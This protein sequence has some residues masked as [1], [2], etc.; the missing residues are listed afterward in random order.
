MKINSGKNC[1]I[2]IYDTNQYPIKGI[3]YRDS[4]VLYGIQLNK[5]TGSQMLYTVFNARD[6]DKGNE[7]YVRIKNYINNTEIDYILNDDPRKDI[8]ERET[9]KQNDPLINLDATYPSK[10]D[11]YYTIC[12]MIFPDLTG[13]ESIS[14]WMQ[15]YW[16]LRKK[17]FI[18]DEYID[19]LFEGQTE[20]LS[21]SWPYDIPFYYYKDGEFYKQLSGVS[22]KL[23]DEQLSELLENAIS[24]QNPETYNYYAEV[25]DFFSLCYLKKCYIYWC[26]QIF[27]NKGFNRCFSSNVDTQTLYKKNLIHSA[28]SVIQY[29]IKCEQYFEAQNLIERLS[30]C[31]GLCKNKETVNCGCERNIRNCGCKK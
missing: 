13:K 20:E 2:N 16:Y 31:N 19:D 12:Q 9:E 15:Y 17:D 8:I 4:V 26:Q 22:T 5:T 18:I 25:V 11:G 30:G 21:D 28:L 24:G 7:R 14:N 1:Q 23:T 10:E 29:M 6:V 27:N 3:E